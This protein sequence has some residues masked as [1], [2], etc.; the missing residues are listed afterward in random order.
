MSQTSG[1]TVRQYERAGIEMPVELEVCETHASQ[2]RFSATS[3]ASGPHVVRGRAVDISPG[4]MGIESR[5]FLPRM[6]E[7]LVRVYAP[8]AV[9]K[10]R[11]GSPLLQLV[12]EQAVKVRRVSQ[13]NREP[14]Y[15]LGVAFVGADVDM[16]N[17]IASLLELIGNAQGTPVAK[18]G[19]R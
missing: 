6:A 5:Q 18:V 16:H 3:S 13:L 9:R 8:D 17:R 2:V 1:L 7:G 11:D 4:G 12:F 10:N 19:S 15:N 14:L